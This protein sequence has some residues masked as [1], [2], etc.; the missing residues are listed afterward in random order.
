MS[1]AGGQPEPPDWLSRIGAELLAKRIEAFWL[2]Q[3]AL[4]VVR[5][6]PLTFGRGRLAFG[7]ASNLSTRGL[8]PA[9]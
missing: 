5:I 9:I 8:P 3:G 2:A 6:V 4:V 1:D 7:I